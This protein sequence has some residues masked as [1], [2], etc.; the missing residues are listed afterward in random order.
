MHQPRMYVCVRVCVSVSELPF[1]FLRVAELIRLLPQQLPLRAATWIR[2]CENPMALI[3]TVAIVLPLE[4]LS[5]KI[6]SPSHYRGNYTSWKTKRNYFNK[7]KAF[8]IE[9][10]FRLI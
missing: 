8:S 10:Q 3:K 5:E 1:A 4:R 2:F 6:H 9:Q 7:R